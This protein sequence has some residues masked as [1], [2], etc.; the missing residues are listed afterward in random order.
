MNPSDTPRPLTDDELSRLLAPVPLEWQQRDAMVRIALRPGLPAD[1]AGPVE[2]DDLR[3]V[4][5]PWHW[6]KYELVVTPNTTALNQLLA[7][8]REAAKAWTQ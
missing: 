1:Y 2:F 5:S 8:A 6:L 7:E 4:L 3:L